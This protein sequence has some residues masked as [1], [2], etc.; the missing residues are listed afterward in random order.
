[1]KKSLMLLA[2][3]AAFIFGC[4]KDDDNTDNGGSNGTKVALQKSWQADEVKGV[5]APVNLSVYKRNRTDNLP[6]I[7]DFSK[8]YVTFK[9]DG[10][11]ERSEIDN[12]NSVTTGTWTLS[13][14]N[15]TIT[16]VSAGG[17][18]TLTYNVEAVDNN[19]ATF[20]YVINVKNPTAL[21]KEIIV[22]AGAKGVV[23]PDGSYLLFNVKPR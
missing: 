20:K 16:M 5:A 4:K 23:L 18:G 21:D 11:F 13:A 1:M 3:S 8:F 22:R 7:V 14:D 17:G 19:S 15:K 12:T 10:T 6:D 2:L 9:A